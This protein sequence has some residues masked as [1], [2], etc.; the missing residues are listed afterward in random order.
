MKG[1]NAN[2]IVES[3][4]E[5]SSNTFSSFR[6]VETWN[7]MDFKLVQL[8]IFI[9]WERE[10]ETKD[11]AVIE[12]SFFDFF[13]IHESHRPWALGNIVKGEFDPRYVSIEFGEKFT[14]IH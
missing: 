8:D 12:V 13:E 3:G 10:R 6:Y 4:K 1:G 5:E 14:W 9:W 11:G 2:K 7:L